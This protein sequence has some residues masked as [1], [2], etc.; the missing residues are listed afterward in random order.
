MVNEAWRVSTHRHKLQTCRPYPY[1]A[2]LSTCFALRTAK[3]WYHWA[4]FPAGMATVV[5]AKLS[6]ELLKQ[7]E[8]KKDGDRARAATMQSL[9]E[10]VR[11]AVRMHIPFALCLAACFRCTPWLGPRSLPCVAP[12]SRYNM[13]YSIIVSS[14]IAVSWTQL[15]LYLGATCHLP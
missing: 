14:I 12:S 4:A 1:S 11:T 2:D 15:L 7:Q 9:S 8:P 6:V 13:S 3:R 5:R 10:A